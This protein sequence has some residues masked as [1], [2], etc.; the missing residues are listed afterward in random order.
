MT[1]LSSTFDPG[2]DRQILI[3][4][5]SRLNQPSDIIFFDLRSIE[6]A[7]SN[8]IEFSHCWKFRRQ[9][10]FLG[11][12]TAWHM[13]WSGNLLFEQGLYES[14]PSGSTLRSESC[15]PAGG[16]YILKVVI[17]E[18]SIMC[19]GRLSHIFVVPAHNLNNFQYWVDLRTILSSNSNSPTIFHPK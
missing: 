7:I 15:I 6:L 3:I 1:L 10:I 14:L 11:L 16:F 19:T 13:P 4:W 2:F 5:T 17:R 18:N 12:L 9:V 8:C